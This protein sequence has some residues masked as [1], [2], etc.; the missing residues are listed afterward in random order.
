MDIHICLLALSK[1]QDKH[2]HLNK[3]LKLKCKWQVFISYK[4]QKQKTTTNTQN[5]L[6]SYGEYLMAKREKVHGL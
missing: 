1:Y 4:L 2:T 6:F 5:K 3:T